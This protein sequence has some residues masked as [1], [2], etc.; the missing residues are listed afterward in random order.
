MFTGVNN[1]QLISEVQTIEK[2]FIKKTE[3]PVQFA[4]LNYTVHSIAKTLHS[5]GLDLPFVKSNTQ[6]YKRY[7]ELSEKISTIV[8]NG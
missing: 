4:S 2:S 3:E 8:N 7:K 5:F 1:K 6:F